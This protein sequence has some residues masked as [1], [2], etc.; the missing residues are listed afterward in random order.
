MV[1]QV[2]EK[3]VNIEFVEKELKNLKKKVKRETAV[4]KIEDFLRKLNKESKPVKTNLRRLF[5]KAELNDKYLKHTVLIQEIKYQ[6][7][8][9]KNRIY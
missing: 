6:Q 5:K 8:Y 3:L 2:Q 1:Q 4:A 9:R 7:F